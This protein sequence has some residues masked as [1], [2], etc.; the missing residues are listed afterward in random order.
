MTKPPVWLDTNILIE[1]DKGKSPLFEIEIANLQKDGHEVLITKNVEHE[2]LNGPK[3]SAQD[4]ARAQGVLDRLK[5]KVDTMANRVPLQQLQA[6]RDEAIRHGLSI[7]D[8][9]VIAHIRASAQARGISN[10]IFYTRDAGGTLGAMR[11]RGVMAVEFKVQAPRPEVHV[12]TPKPPPPPRPSFVRARLNTA[13]FALKEGIKGAFS[14][15]GIASMIPDVILAVADRVAAKEAIKNIQKKFLKE[16]FGKG[17]AAGVMGWT[18]DEVQSELKNRITPFRV[19]GMEDP[20]GFL[21][22]SYILQLA[23]ACE[24]YGV[25][26]GSQW[27]RA[28]S[29]AWKKDMVTKGMSLLVKYN[30]HYPDNPDLLFTYDFV[31]KLAWVL[32]STTDAIVEPAIRF[33]D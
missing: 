23:E 5:I 30:Y 15:E 12:S 28:K 7:P 19:Q 33:G 26:V 27:S 1:I 11:R 18:D 32:R 17:V 31:D 3:F 20:A 13:K 14:P 25:D 21:T 22:R 9:D 29:L 8:A 10:P 16:G 4:T 2:F 24:N 6:W